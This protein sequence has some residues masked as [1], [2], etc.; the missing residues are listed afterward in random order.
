MKRLPLHRRTRQILKELS[1]KYG[2]EIP[3]AE[4]FAEIAELNEAVRK[5]FEPAELDEL[6]I[7]D[8]PVEVGGTK[9][10]ALTLNAEDWFEAWCKHFPDAPEMQMAGFLYASAHS[11]EPEALMRTWQDKFKLAE[12]VW[13]WRAKCG[14]K[15]RQIAPLQ[16][17]LMPET[18]WPKG[19]EGKGD[20][21]REGYAGFGWMTGVLCTVKPD[22][23]YWRNKVPFL[24]AMQHYRNAVFYGE[25]NTEIKNARWEQW[26]NSAQMEEVLAIKHLKE[27]WEALDALRAATPS[28]PPSEVQEAQGEASRMQESANPEECDL[29]DGGLDAR[30]GAHLSRMEEG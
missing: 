17:L 30:V 7:L 26:R 8:A 29:S 23:D 3:W 16:Q 24:K 28:P 25:S 14:L 2:T 5:C 15:R 6:A 19:D 13:A 21:E 9:F 1:Q 22:P 20:V 12:H 10:Y 4:L 27:A 11:M 18:P